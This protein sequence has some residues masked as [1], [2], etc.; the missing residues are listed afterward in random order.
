MVLS[1]GLTHSQIKAVL[2]IICPLLE[3]GPT[4]MLVLIPLPSH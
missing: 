1:V 4:W 3:K 2:G